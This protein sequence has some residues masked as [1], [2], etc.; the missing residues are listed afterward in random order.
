M[1]QHVVH[2]AVGQLPKLGPARLTHWIERL[3]WSII[4]VNS[5][6]SRSPLSYS[7]T[8]RPPSPPGSCAQIGAGL[9]IQYEHFRAAALRT[10]ARAAP[11]TYAAAGRRDSHSGDELPLRPGC[12]HRPGSRPGRRYRSDL[13][14]L[15]RLPCCPT[16]R[17]EDYTLPDDVEYRSRYHRR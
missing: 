15:H 1:V 12:H 11:S 3:L 2:H 17:T 14:G 16:R 7:R 5:V 4:R 6:H 13:L 10:S 8:T 9:T